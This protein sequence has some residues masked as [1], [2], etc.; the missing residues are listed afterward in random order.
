MENNPPT[1]VEEW[2]QQEVEDAARAAF[3]GHNLRVFDEVYEDWET[4]QEH[5][6]T[7]DELLERLLIKEGPESARWV[8]RQSTPH[9]IIEH[10]RRNGGRIVYQESGQV[11]SLVLESLFRSAADIRPRRQSWLWSGRIPLALPT[12]LAGVQ[13]LGKSTFTAWLASLVTKAGKDVML[14]STEDDPETTIVPRLIVAG[15]D[16]KRVHLHQIEHPL[17]FPQDLEKLDQAVGYFEAG[18]VIVDPIMSYLDDA[19]DAFSP[20]EV[21][22]AFEAIAAVGKKHQSTM[23]AIMHFRKQ[24][25]SEVLHMITS[26]SAFTEAP[27]SVLGL[28]RDPEKEG[29]L[30]LVHLKCNV[31]KKQRTLRMEIEEAFI[32]DPDGGEA[33]ETSRIVIGEECDLT[34][35]QVFM[36]K[37]GRP[38]E[39]AS[40]TAVFLRELLTRHGGRVPVAVA[41]KE[42]H[43]SGIGSERTL[44]RTVTQLGL[45]TQRVEGRWIWLE[46][47]AP[48]I[49]E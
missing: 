43:E 45:A 24:S 46:S 22:R 7:W 31:G 41:K 39:K 37:P 27:R 38:P 4:W 47:D 23:I 48:L 18:V 2:D 36:A 12:L 9:E 30:A 25:A 44:E 17:A 29:G 6:G 3:S 11:I 14:L 49:G 40:E 20:K 10:A 1:S 28:G 33:I 8:R 42:Y 26:S 21:R 5:I 15:A 19:T 32:D 13:G 35:E 34:Q 16:L